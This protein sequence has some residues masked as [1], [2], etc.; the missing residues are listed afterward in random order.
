MTVKEYYLKHFDELPEEK[1]FHLATRLKN[2]FGGTEFDEFLAEHEPSH[3][4]APLLTNDDYSRVN[5][6]DERRPFFEKYKG[7]Y[8]LEAT[9]CRVLH[10][11]MEY[12]VDLR[13]DLLDAYGRERLSGLCDKLR[14]DDGC[15]FVLTTW[16]V[17]VLAL[18]EEMY[19]RGIDVYKE[20]LVKTLAHEQTVMCVYLYTHIM[21]CESRFYRNKELKHLDLYR[22]A[23]QNCDRIIAENFDE[24]TLDMKFEF[25]VC[26]QM[27]GYEVQCKEKIRAEADLNKG[28]FVK[29]PRK[30]DRLNTLAGAEHRNVLYMMSGL[31]I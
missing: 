2:W 16:V 6:I 28:D 13:E 27:V 5:F 1:R 14:N 7:I 3:D 22:E 31:D 17:N 29:D 20:M 8:A 19:P 12:G 24:V 30:A 25:L 10:L 15:L 26:A 11:W 18:T 4:L 21:L 23:M 9:L